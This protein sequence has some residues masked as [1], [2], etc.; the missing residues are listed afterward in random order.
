M[1]LVLNCQT[2]LKLLSLDSAIDQQRIE[3]EEEEQL[4]EAIRLSLEQPRIGLEEQ[5][6]LEQVNRL[7]LEAGRIISIL[8]FLFLSLSKVKLLKLKL[9]QRKDS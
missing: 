6:Q 1:I 2:S 9:R 7:S 3:R 4:E 5:E 8:S